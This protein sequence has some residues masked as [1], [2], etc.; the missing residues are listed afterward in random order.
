MIKVNLD[1]INEELVRFNAAVN[2]FKPYTEGFVKNTSEKLNGFNSDFIDGLKDLL[3][4]MT[5]SKA[6][7]LLK[8]AESLYNATKKT[9]E[10]YENLENEISKNINKK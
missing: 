6:P 8:R 3:D 1:E 4:S 7:K 9:M 5:D 10:G 2:N